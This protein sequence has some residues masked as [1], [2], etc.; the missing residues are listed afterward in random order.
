MSGNTS[1]PLEI[2]E[3]YMKKIGGP[4]ENRQ[5]IHLLD[6]FGFRTELLEF[7]CFKVGDLFS[8]LIHL[9][10]LREKRSYPDP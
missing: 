2:S 4:V 6:C 1:H 5:L 8:Q 3:F 10:C 9:C 7:E